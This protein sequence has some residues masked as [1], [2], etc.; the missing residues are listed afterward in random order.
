M[1]GSLAGGTAPLAYR[2]TNC[3]TLERNV[4]TEQAQNASIDDG[5]VIGHPLDVIE[6]VG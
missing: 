2:R 5:D 6:Q 3:R 4:S 1:V